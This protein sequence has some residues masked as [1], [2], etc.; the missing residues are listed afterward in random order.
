MSFL[1]LI[2]MG[3][4]IAWVVSNLLKRRLDFRS[5]LRWG[6]GLGFLFTGVDHFVNASTR[7]VPMIPD[8][9]AEHAFA[10]VYLT[11]VAELAG[12]LALLIP[13]EFYRRLALPNLQKQAGLWLAVMLFFVVAANINVALKG[14]TVQGLEFGAWYFWIRPLFQ[15]FFIIWAL[16]CVGVWPKRRQAAA[17][18]QS[19]QSAKSIDV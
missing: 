11:G 17:I 13:A 15:P 3:A 16:Y 19:T 4:G 7:Y 9:L 2:C 14:Q 1:L 8:A 6:M 10:W 5:S 12:G 18:K